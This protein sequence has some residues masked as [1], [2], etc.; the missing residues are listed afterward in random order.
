MRLLHQRGHPDGGEGSFRER[1]TEEEKG[2]G[3]VQQEGR[4]KEEVK[5]PKEGNRSLIHG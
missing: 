1:G 2:Q 5:I 4:W 3:Q